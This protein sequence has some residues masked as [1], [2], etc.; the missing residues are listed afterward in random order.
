MQLSQFKLTVH[1]TDTYN[2]VHLTTI[3]FYLFF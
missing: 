2:T 1:T 3:V